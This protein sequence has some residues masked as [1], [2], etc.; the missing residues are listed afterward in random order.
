M[1][2]TT[3]F[4]VLATALLGFV[5]AIWSSSGIWNIAIKL[6]FVG[7]TV[8]GAIVSAAALGVQP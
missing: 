4:I 2:L 7:A 3:F 6:T 1:T 5:A 8:L